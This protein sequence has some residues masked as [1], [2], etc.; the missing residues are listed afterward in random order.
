MHLRDDAR[1]AEAVGGGEP[2]ETCTDDDDAARGDRG[3]GLARERAR[4]GDREAEEPG[5]AQQLRAGRAPFLGDLLR[6]VEERPLH[7]RGQRCACHR[8]SPRVDPRIRVGR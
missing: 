5:V 2:G 7:E 8:P 4:T 1:L 3:G 6:G